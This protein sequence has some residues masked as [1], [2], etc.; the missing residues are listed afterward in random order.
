[1]SGNWIRGKGRMLLQQ[2]SA[3]VN[4]YRHPALPGL[5]IA[6]DITRPTKTRP[7]W[8]ITH[9]STGLM[10]AKTKSQML[11]RDV[12]RLTLMHLGEAVRIDWTQKAEDLCSDAQ[13][14]WAVG[15]LTIALGD[16]K[17]G[18]QKSEQPRQ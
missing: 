1:M 13:A 17:K 11:L 3:V 4:C 18:R 9:D 15:Q 10:L 14:R 12:K 8:S 6:R 2:G 7:H 16:K 5:F